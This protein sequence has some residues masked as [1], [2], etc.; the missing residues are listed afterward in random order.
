MTILNDTTV[1][2]FTS[3]ELKT[4]L[5]NNNNYTYIYFGNDITLG[6]GINISSLK[7]NVTIDGTYDNVRHKFSDMKS[8]ATGNTI[9]IS[10]SNTKKVTVSNMD[11]T[12]YNYYGIIYVAE[13]SGY[14]DTEVLYNN[15]TY[16][17]P[18]ISFN[19]WGITT[20]YDC[21]ITIL[22]NYAAANE[23]AECNRINIGG[24]TTIL[25]KSTGNSSFWFRNSNPSL[26]ILE[27]ATVDFTSENR[28][29][30]YGVNDLEFNI[31]SNAVFKVTTKNGLSY[32]TFGTGAT[33]IYN[34]ASFI[35]KKTAYSGGYATWYSSKAITLNENSSLEI[36][37][38]YP[39]ITSSNYNIYFT[40]SN[41]SFILNNPKYVLLYNSVGN[42]IYSQNS[43]P[44]E[45]NFS[46]INLF[47]NTVEKNSQ[48][49][50]SNLPTYS[51][52]KNNDL[53]TITGKFTA[54][55]TTITSN[56][57]ETS[58][59]EELP[60]LTNFNFVNKRILSIGIVSLHINALTD[61]DT[62]L[63][64][65]TLPNAS[66]LIEYNN[67]NETVLAD[68]TGNFSYDFNETLPVGTTFTITSKKDNDLIYTTKKIT[69][70]YSGELTIDEASKVINFTLNPIS[71]DPVLLPKSE[72]L[73]IKV[74]DS[75][76]N[77]TDWKL[78]A[79][80][81][82]NLSSDNEELEDSLVFVDS[83][84]N[85][86]VLSD[87]KTL[88]YQGTSNEGN[89][90]ETEI[91]FDVD[92]G[93]LAQVKNYVKINSSYNATITWLLEE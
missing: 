64:G 4:A 70:V 13:N 22:E 34:N 75:R 12:G 81:N 3:A 26:T 32:A 74:T 52:Y 59:L 38:D 7:T 71:L 17:G 40:S 47:S 50:S 37:N 16:T 5:E 8:L 43:I 88:V 35:L 63:K 31:L 2:V 41:S 68:T 76:I 36:I 89:I 21:S 57:F 56:N 11:I 58:E 30:I 51:W 48:I 29:L 42:I 66:I 61:E 91:N 28:E 85:I 79:I 87:T 77:S 93:I 83:D 86:N 14:K 80:I 6:S 72:N 24:N 67:M 78:Y 20:F 62:V 92:K 23:V 25:H 46:R 33:T 53:A 39:S 54:S 45:F 69:I 73:Q 27:N 19:P 90:K 65:K 18:Q 55:K 1:V 82:H 15:I 44:Y 49:T 10:S 9:S 84:N 60:N